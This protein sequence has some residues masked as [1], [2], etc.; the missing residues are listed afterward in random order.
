MNGVAVQAQTI[1]EEAVRLLTAVY[2][3]EDAGMVWKSL[4]EALGPIKGALALKDKPITKRKLPLH[5]GDAILIA[6]GDQIVESERPPLQTLKYFLDRY[7]C[8]SVSTVHLLPHFPYTSDDGFS[9]VDYK[10]VDPALGDW[11]DVQNLTENFRL[12][13]DAVINHISSKSDWFQYYLDGVPSYQ[14]YFIEADPATDLSG[15]YRPRALPLL[16]PFS[17]RNGSRHVWTTFSADQIDLNFANP[18]VFVEIIDVLLSYVKYGATLLRLDAVGFLWK[19]LGTDCFHRPQTHM[20]V[21]LMRLVLDLVNPD[22]VLVPEINGPLQESTPYFGDGSDE[23][24]M[25]Y[26][27]PLAPLT[28]DA[29]ARGDA[30]VLSGWLETLPQPTGQTT[31]FNFLAS[32]DG[33]SVRSASGLL[34]ESQ[35][36]QLV[37][38]T[39]SCGGKVNFRFGPQGEKIPYELATTLYD[40]LSVNYSQD[41]ALARFHC[42]HAIMCSMAGV[43]GIYF[44]S[45]FGTSNWQEGYAKTQHAR[46]LNRR[47]FELHELQSLL[48]DSSSRA[49]RIHAAMTKLLKARAAEPAFHPAAPQ[50]ILTTPPEVVGIE[51]IRPDQS[52][53]VRAFH[54]VSGRVITCSL[55]DVI[56][57]GS[58]L[59]GGDSVF[60]S[61]EITLRPYEAK[62]LQVKL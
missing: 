45:F 32:H 31:L 4:C 54:N 56:A 39:E 42:A 29:F 36:Q 21:K 58:D 62:W 37:T 34:T 46:T 57:S 25:V 13:I 47:K 27:F 3:P 24:Q 52:A 17:T 26:N 10:A 16:T 1:S 22:V 12:M 8:E 48:E 50:K 5:Q 38:L 30:S 55:S 41:E 11:N 59:L 6:Y 53:C 43:P 23:A 15:V 49:A 40:V 7:L 19:E 28:L 18:Q 35:L 51:R 61:R 2:G 14:N 9:V 44:H 20:L 33:I 60:D